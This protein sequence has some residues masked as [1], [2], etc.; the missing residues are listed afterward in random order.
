MSNKINL[1]EEALKRYI[2]EAV[3]YELYEML[4][5]DTWYKPW[6]WGRDS[7][8]EKWGYTW[9]DSLSDSEN[10]RRRDLNRANIRILGYDNAKEYEAGEGHKY[11]ETP[12]E[13]TWDDTEEEARVVFPPEEYPYKADKNKTAQFQTWFNQ[14][15]GGNLV[16]DG[17]WGPNTENAYQIWQN[18]EENALKRAYGV[19]SEG[20]L[21][22]REI[23]L[24]S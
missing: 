23:V 17:I 8:N 10:R 20:Y 16:V 2:D 11:G 13:E 22:L 4:D 15:L 14:V 18:S 1:N 21:R 7:K 24:N 12:E 19:V 6:T 5:E 9:D 3:R